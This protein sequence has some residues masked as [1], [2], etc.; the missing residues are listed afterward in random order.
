MLSAEKYAVPSTVI[1]P[2]NYFVLQ[3]LYTCAAMLCAAKLA[4]TKLD[5]AK[6][7]ELARCKK[8]ELLGNFH[9]YQ[10]IL[11]WTNR[12]VNLKIQ[13]CTASTGTMLEIKLENNFLCR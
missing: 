4:N 1:I 3:P 9:L 7:V 2:M 10:R 8:K 11:R 6:L 12:K 13:I 5:V